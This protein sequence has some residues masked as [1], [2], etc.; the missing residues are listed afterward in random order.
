MCVCEYSSRITP[1]TAWSPG[2]LINY[3]PW[4]DAH[5]NG[6]PCKEDIPLPDFNWTWKGKWRIDYGKQVLSLADSTD[7]TR[8][9]TVPSTDAEGW[10]YALTWGATWGPSPTPTTFVRRRKWVCTRVLKTKD[11][12]SQSLQ[13]SSDS[14][15]HIE[16]LIDEFEVMTPSPKSTV[17]EATE[18]DQATATSTSTSTSSTTTTTS[19]VPILPLESLLEQPVGAQE[20]AFVNEP[21]VSHTGATGDAAPLEDDGDNEYSRFTSEFRS[22]SPPH[23]SA[24]SSEQ[25]EQILFLLAQQERLRV[26]EEANMQRL[27]LEYEQK[28]QQ[29][30]VEQREREQ[31]WIKSQ[32]QLRQKLQEE[33][34]RLQHIQQLHHQHHH[35]QQQQP[36]SQQEEQGEQEEQAHQQEQHDQD[37]S[38]SNDQ[39]TL[40]ES[41]ATTTSPLPITTS[42]VEVPATT[43]NTILQVEPPPNTIVDATSIPESSS[44]PT[45]Q[46]EELL[47]P[48]PATP[49]TPFL[50]SFESSA[51]EGD[52]VE[53]M[54]EAVSD[55][56]EDGDDN[57]GD[58]D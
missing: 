53:A 58:A 12:K 9:P 46:Q 20:G 52:D 25:D 34:S 5:G 26:E 23:A 11:E 39:S 31:A 6:L 42:S 40:L 19:T 57:H 50:L 44:E 55:D 56:E 47:P 41:P 10:Q 21:P 22:P 18:Q 16:N 2:N 38:S 29:R 28:R 27:Q 32:E 4:S 35:P 15:A 33:E 49:A 7:S 3:P 37:S 51:L 45:Q 17:V 14:I 8:A 36:L 24:A 13:P 1:F 43:D 48:V 30:E 54:F